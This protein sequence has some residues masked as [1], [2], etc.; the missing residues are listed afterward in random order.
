MTVHLD[1]APTHPA[2]TH[3]AFDDDVYARARRRDLDVSLVSEAVEYLL[4]PRRDCP[5][6]WVAAVVAIDAGVGIST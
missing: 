1:L 3:R 5:S 4:R 6:L 2:T